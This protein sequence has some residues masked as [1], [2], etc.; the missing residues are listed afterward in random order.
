MTLDCLF[1]SLTFRGQVVKNVTAASEL[2]LRERI[3]LV[4]T[5]RNPKRQRGTCKA[6]ATSG[7]PSLGARQMEFYV[8]AGLPSPARMRFRRPWKASVQ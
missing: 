1:L 8:Y 4:S 2:V 5:H 3:E 6:A 7:N